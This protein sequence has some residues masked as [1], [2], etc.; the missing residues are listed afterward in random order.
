M[1][2]RSYQEEEGSR[3]KGQLALHYM[4]DY[5]EEEGVHRGG[6]GVAGCGSRANNVF[7]MRLQLVTGEGEDQLPQLPQLETG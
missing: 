2:G 3:G 5:Q 6:D 4:Q 7:A 1:L